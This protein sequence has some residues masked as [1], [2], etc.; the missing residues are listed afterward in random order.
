MRP[1]EFEDYL[2]TRKNLSLYK[3]A[4]ILRSC[5]VL[6]SLSLVANCQKVIKRD[7]AVRDPTLSTPI[8]FK[9]FEQLNVTMA[10]LT[11]V[12]K[13][14]M[15]DAVKKVV[16]QLPSNADP[17]TFGASQ[18]AAISKLADDYCDKLMKDANLRA[19]IYPDINFGARVSQV[20]DAKGQRDLI[21]STIKR[22]FGESGDL[23]TART[24]LA[25][26]TKDLVAAALHGNPQIGTDG[27]KENTSLND[28]TEGTRAVAVGVCSA[29][30]ASTPVTMFSPY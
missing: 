29:A 17:Q 15:N 4:K 8:G 5:A 13:K 12:D 11:G 9:D 20:Y 27:T 25:S 22:F 16:N 19:R 24:E 26:L 10:T 2:M 18:Q 1:L 30:L 6:F 28:D 21:D 7:A 3:A 14:S 23:D